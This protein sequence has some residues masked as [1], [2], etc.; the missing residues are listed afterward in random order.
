MLFHAGALWRLNEMGLLPRLNQIASV[1]AG[2]IAAGVLWHAWPRL[3]FDSTGRARLFE[4]EV[5]RPLRDLASKTID[6]NIALLGI[7]KSDRGNHLARFYRRHLFGSTT[8]QD[9]PNSTDGPKFLM[10]AWNVQ[11]GSLWTF[12]KAFMG[13]YTVGWIS[14][15]KVTLADAVAAS[16]AVPPI[17][18]P[19]ILRLDH[20]DFKAGRFTTLKHPPFTTRVV[21]TDGGVYDNLALENVWKNNGTV[22]V[23]DGAAAQLPLENP[24]LDW[25]SQIMRIHNSTN[26]QLRRLRR[27][28]L[29]TSFMEPPGNE[30]HREGTYWGITTDIRDYSLGDALHISPEKTYALST[31]PTR[32]GSMPMPM[33]ERLINWGYALCDAAMRRH[34]A[35]SLPD[36]DLTPPKGFPYPK[37]G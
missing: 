28:Q 17:L 37:A 8:L 5:I 1:S 30:E 10:S 18:S 6:L 19:L 9:L 25:A 7:L 24:D 26:A 22:L 36:L 31:S 27:F 34:V 20:A 32:F 12:S 21:L 2:S 33:Q 11:S 3:D 15:P 14:N 4:Q 35:G 13:D 29:L 16:S 23:S